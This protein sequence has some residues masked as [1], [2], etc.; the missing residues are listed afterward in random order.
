M[1]LVMAA[2]C[3]PDAQRKAQEQL[4]LVVGQERSTPS[5]WTNRPC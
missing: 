1:V 3:F 2:A 4:D 5:P